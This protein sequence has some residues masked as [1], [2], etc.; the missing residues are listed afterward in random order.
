MQD[1][2]IHEQLDCY[3]ARAVEYDESLLSEAT[4]GEER[5]PPEAEELV[6]ARQA[7]LALGPRSTVLELAGGTGIWTQELVGIAAD[8]TV[9]DGS[10]EMLAI[11]KS[12]L[13]AERI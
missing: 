5:D 2:L 12:K 3:R 8:L 7:L 10:P 9:L 13:Q 4:P 1:R 6:Q 11:N